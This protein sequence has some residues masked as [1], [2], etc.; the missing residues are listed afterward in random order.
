MKATRKII[1]LLLSVIIFTLS[2]PF[3][4]SAEEES[5]FGR[6]IL[7]GMDNSAALVSCYDEIK[8]GCERLSSKISLTKNITVE[9]LRT[10]ILALTNDCPEI[11]WFTGGY[12]Y[13]HE[14]GSTTVSYIEPEYLFHRS[15][16]AAAKSALESMAE[17]MLEGLSGKSEYDKALII[18]DRLA[19]RVVYAPTDNDQ[20]A[21]GAIVEGEAVCAGYARAYHYL[22]SKVGITAWSVQGE[23]INPS[24]DKKESHRWNM[25]KLDGK[26]YYTDVTWDDQ[27]GLLY[28]NYFN[29]TLSYFNKTHFPDMFTEYLPDDNSTELDYF[30]RNN[31]VFR[32][33]ETNRIIKL[34]K[35]SN[36]NI[37]LYVDGNVDSFLKSLS[38]KM[39]TIVQSLGAKGGASYSYT[40]T[41]LGNEVF[42]KLVI[43]QSGHTHSLKKV[44]GSP[45][46]CY[47][48]GTKD[49]Y[50]CSCGRIFAD[51]KGKKELPSP[52][53]L[54]K[55]AH[56]ES[57][58]WR[59]DNMAHWKYC[60]VCDADIDTASALHKDDDEDRQCD[61]CSTEVTEIFEEIESKESKEVD[62]P[63]SPTALGMAVIVIAVVVLFTKF[64]RR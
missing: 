34:L 29:R 37:S 52:E 54:E 42:L 47:Q 43:E 32:S 9:E 57:D 33:V 18:H 62:P 17:K 5:R 53:V 58:E 56:S 40:T 22:L 10:V 20:T 30:K 51:S 48:T 1:I 38:N 16:T 55:T 44:S 13:A 26:W 2:L 60:T 11:F 50:K 31:L 14:E 63:I 35:D 61:I 23:S 21:Y 49:Y 8:E 4:A 27:E 25:V 28:H 3:S 59:Y 19:E 7:S 64:L 46:T 36:N 39:T 45:A 41:Q 24:T 6:S 12:S 15:K